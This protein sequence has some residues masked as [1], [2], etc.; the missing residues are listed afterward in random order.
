LVLTEMEIRLK[1]YIIYIDNKTINVFHAMSCR[2]IFYHLIPK[3]EN[4]G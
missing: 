1:S 3:E 2:P 4:Y